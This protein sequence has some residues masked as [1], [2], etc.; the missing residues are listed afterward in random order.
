MSMNF[1]FSRGYGQCQAVQAIGMCCYSNT[2]SAE[3][4]LKQQR[5]TVRSI[6]RY[7]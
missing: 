7:A 3:V 2:S 1:R 5:A 4:L 6:D